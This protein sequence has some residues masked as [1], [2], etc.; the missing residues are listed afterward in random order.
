MFIAYLMMTFF[1]IGILFGNLN[2]LAMEPL[3]HLA[4]VGSAVVGSLSTLIS[5]ILG[6]M[7]GRSYDGTVLPL[8]ASIAIFGGLS[9]LVMRW[10]ESGQESLISA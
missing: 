3:G 6:T 5:M 2:S 1:C 4:G 8:V 10:T 7:I 9:I